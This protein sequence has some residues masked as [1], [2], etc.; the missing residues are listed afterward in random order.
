M[1][2]STMILGG[3]FAIGALLGGCATRMAAT[4]AALQG[5]RAVAGQLRDGAG[6]SVELTSN[7][8]RGTVIGGSV[9]QHMD[10]QDRHI[11]GLALSDAAARQAIRWYNTD[12]GIRYVLVPVSTFEGPDGPCRRFTIVASASGQPQFAD[13]LA[14]QQSDGRWI[15]TR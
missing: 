11:A 14:C 13:G 2:K 7:V 3:A 15:E 12:T 9:G 1:H 5:S 6:S 10:A 8:V 4:P